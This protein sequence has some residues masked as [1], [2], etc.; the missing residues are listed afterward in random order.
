MWR[1]ENMSQIPLI[2]RHAEYT[3]HYN[4]SKSPM[5]I[6]PGLLIIYATHDNAIGNSNITDGIS[7]G[8][9]EDE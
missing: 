7:K 8:K 2:T 3:L 4:T 5:M 9:V 6:N 1:P